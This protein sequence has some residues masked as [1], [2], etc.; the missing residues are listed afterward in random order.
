MNVNVKRESFVKVLGHS[1][2]VPNALILERK[3]WS[4]ARKNRARD[5][6]ARLGKVQTF[7]T[8]RTAG[9]AYPVTVGVT[10]L[11]SLGVVG[12]IESR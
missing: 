10:L 6:A 2:R 7:V 9:A 8:A 12:S 4:A 11:A 5:N 1:V 3:P